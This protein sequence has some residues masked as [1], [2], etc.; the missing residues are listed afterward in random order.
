VRGGFTRAASLAPFVAA[1]GAVAALLVATPTL[2]LDDLRIAEL[3]R[4]TFHGH[5]FHGLLTVGLNLD[6]G[7]TELRTFGLARLVQDLY[8]ALFGSAPVAVYSFNVG[9]H[10]AS[11]LLVYGVFRRMQPDRLTALFAAIAWAASPAVLPLLKPQHHLLYVVAPYYG[12]FAWVFLAWASGQ[13]AG[14]WLSGAAL[15]IAAWWFG[16]GALV[17]TGVVVLLAVL[18]RQHRLAAPALWQGIAAG[19]L[20]LAYVA[21]QVI[22]VRDT[23]APQRFHLASER[24]Y[25]GAFVEQLGQAGRAVLGLAHYDAELRRSLGSIGLLDSRVTW[26]TL[27]LLIPSALLAARM[28]ELQTG[29]W[30]RDVALQVTALWPASLGVYGL[31]AIAG[32]GVFAVRYAAAFFALLPLAAIAVAV[33]AG[34]ARRARA[35]AGLLAAVSLALSVGALQRAE[36]LVNRPNR[37]ILQ[38]LHRK[39]VVLRSDAGFSTD[40]A[41]FHALRGLSPIDAN[42]LANPM[43]SL[44]TSELALRQSAGAVLATTCRALADGSV[45]IALAGQPRGTYYLGDVIVVGA[46]TRPAQACTRP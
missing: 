43:R 37:A 26:A 13:T 23:S 1:L 10:F 16:E 4:P 24:L 40:P 42:G 36:V 44:W 39:V 25:V 20:L 31:F 33:G 46:V 27:A 9:L 18:Q 7:A 22:Y 34:E 8:I 12:L 3:V 32:I 28:T 17:A 14:Y 19:G 30:R 45:E 29:T 11:G 41:D 21:F 5:W 15:L 35:I 6:V 2:N 38:A